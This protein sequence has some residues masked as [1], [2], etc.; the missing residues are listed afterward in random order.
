MISKSHLSRSVLSLGSCKSE[1]KRVVNMV[2]DPKKILINNREGQHNMLLSRRL[3]EA[4]SIDGRNVT[5]ERLQGKRG[6]LIPDI[7]VTQR[8]GEM[9]NL[10]IL[11]PKRSTCLQSRC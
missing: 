4:D 6:H 3:T 7:S 9:I 10:E 2:K 5:T 8:W 11:L 1:I